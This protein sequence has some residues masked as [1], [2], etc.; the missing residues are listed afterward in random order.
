MTGYEMDVLESFRPIEAKMGSVQHFAKLIKA[1]IG[2]SIFFADD[3]I[4]FLL[5]LPSLPIRGVSMYLVS[6]AGYTNSGLLEE[7]ASSYLFK[8]WKTDMNYCRHIKPVCV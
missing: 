2:K 1:K 8:S 4:M 5:V 3:Y 6:F 7:G